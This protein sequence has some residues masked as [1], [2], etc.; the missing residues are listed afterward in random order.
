MTIENKTIEITR[1]D[2]EG[3]SGDTSKERYR[4]KLINSLSGP[5]G[6][7]LIGTTSR[8]RDN[9]AIFTNVFHL[10][11]NPA[12]MGMIVRPDISPRHTLA[13]ILETGHF[14]VNHIPYDMIAKAHHTSARFAE[15]VSEFNA[16]E[17]PIEYKGEAKIPFVIDSPVKWL[18]KFIRKIDIEEN[19]T[20][21]VIAQVESLYVRENLLG[22]DGQLKL[23]SDTSSVAVGLDEY[24][25]LGESMRLSYAKPD[26]KPTVIKK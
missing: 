15:E 2:L 23:D 4:I 8:G 26:I 9:G 12:L 21:M 24:F 22:E 10:G 1:H 17:I 6:T 25:E 19:G 7:F 13:N 16:C 11:A 18:M 14:S 20:H 5:K 3:M